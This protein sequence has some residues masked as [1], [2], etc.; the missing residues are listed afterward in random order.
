MDQHDI[1]TEKSQLLRLPWSPF[2]AGTVTGI[3]DAPNV[4]NRC[5][6]GAFTNSL[7]DSD[8]ST[9]YLLLQRRLRDRVHSR[10]G[11]I[12]RDIKPASL[13]VGHDGYLVMANLSIAERVGKADRGW[14]WGPP[15]IWHLS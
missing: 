12:S 4:S 3:S 7:T 5:L 15:N 6:M 14:T 10:H 8:P 11:L 1:N 13:L 9:R 2:V